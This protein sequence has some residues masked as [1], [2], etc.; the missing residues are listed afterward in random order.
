MLWLPAIPQTSST[1]PADWARE[2]SSTVERRGR[3]KVAALQAGRVAAVSASAKSSSTPRPQRQRCSAG[4]NRILNQKFGTE[5]PLAPSA[6]ISPAQ[7][8]TLPG[9]I[10]GTPGGHCEG[11]SAHT[12][13]YA[14]ICNNIHLACPCS[15]RPQK[16]H[17]C[18]R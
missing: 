10:A 12:Y 5:Q 8:T 4:R 1:S 18:W 16:S 17:R 6:R 14:E 7:V 9:W 3:G 2:R 13:S 11:R 15:C